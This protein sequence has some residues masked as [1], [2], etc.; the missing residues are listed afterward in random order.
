MKKN[1][2][3]IFTIIF[4]CLSLWL[5]GRHEMWR[6][7]LQAWLLV[8]DS[9]NFLSLSENLKYE[10]HPGLWHFILFP[11]TRITNDPYFMQLLHLFISTC[12]IFV[13]FKWSPFSKLQKVFLTFSYFL[14]YEY[15]LIARSYGLS[16]L[17]IFVFCTLFENKKKNI[18]KI[19]IVLALLSHSSIFGLIMALCLFF[20]IIIQYVIEYPLPKKGFRGYLRKSN[21]IAFSIFIFGFLSSLLQ[22]IPPQDSPLVNTNINVP[23][24]NSFISLSKDI[25]KSYIPIP[26][27]KFSFWESSISSNSFILE[28]FFVI[29]FISV[30]SIFLNYFRKKP[31]VLFLYVSSSF[32]LS[33]FFLL[34]FTGSLRH[35]GFLFLTL[36]SSLWIFKHCTS[37]NQI[38]DQ[39]NLNKK[40]NLAITSLFGLQAMA[41][42]I[43]ASIDAIYPFSSAKETADFLI[44]NNLT[45][46]KIISYRDFA[47]SSVLGHLP[48]R[49]EFYYLD[50]AQNGSFIKWNNK[51]I[52]EVKNKDLEEASLKL[53]SGGNEVILI[54]N[55]SIEKFGFDNTKFK[56]IFVSKEAIVKDEK[57]YIYKF[58]G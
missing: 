12:S 21:F 49:K 53:S 57:F 43:A 25:I 7:E 31:A 36:I 15:S 58:D 10:G 45:N 48:D 30:I 51:R 1:F 47:G 16:T 55:K 39:K 40:V 44:K 3:S 28:I 33:S 14:F 2:T 17:L 50:S 37:R 29:F 41:G 34:K 56:E 26:D 18:I 19:S 35:H 11:L 5:L 6:D 23:N 20:S 27:V 32:I 46:T 38:K 22:L 54:L 4:A 52:R 13:L 24:L 8:R 42:I 9:S